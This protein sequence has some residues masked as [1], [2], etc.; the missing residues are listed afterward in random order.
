VGVGIRRA[1]ISIGWCK[2]RG[3]RGE[4][5]FALNPI[6]DSCITHLNTNMGTGRSR[7]GGTPLLQTGSGPR[8]IGARTISGSGY[9]AEIPPQRDRPYGM[10]S[11]TGV[12]PR[13]D[14][15]YKSCYTILM[16]A[17]FFT[18]IFIL[19]SLTVGAVLWWRS[20][21][22]NEG[23]A[24]ETVNVTVPGPTSSI[25]VG[26]WTL[27]GNDVVWGDTSTEIKDVSGYA[28]HGNSSN[29]AAGSATAGRIG[30]GIVFNG[31]SDSVSLG[32][33]YNGVKTVAFW[34]KPNS[35]TQSII[36]LNATATVDIN[37]G[38]V[39]GNNFST[40]TVYVDGA[41]TTTFPDTAWHHIAITTA[42][43]INASAAYLGK[44][45]S[46]Y[47][48]GTLDDIRFYSTEF[49]ATQVADLYKSSGAKQT[50][51]FGM[52][53]T[54][55]D[56]LVG[57]WTMDGDDVKWSDTGTEIKDLSTN[58]NHGDATGTTPVRGKLGQGLQFNG[59]SDYVKLGQSTLAQI[60]V[61]LWFFYNQT[62][63]SGNYALFHRGYAGSCAYSPLISINDLDKLEIAKTDFSCG[64]S[65]AISISK[66]QWN[67]IVMTA[68]NGSQTVYLNGN[69]AANMTDSFSSETYYSTAG[70]AM[71]NDDGNATG[72]YL[73]GKIDD[74][75][76]Y[77]RVLSPM[78]VSNLYNMGK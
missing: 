46:S 7:L 57:H 63:S 11:G 69:L 21:G 29:L 36:D 76:I 48:G 65:A 64:T 75:R 51:S 53:G 35:T 44:I 71:Q 78:E 40:P 49:T 60:S 66:N 3:C 23:K 9:R 67:H 17:R 62:P 26:H 34:V 31:T 13:R 30:Q 59:T 4:I 61:S 24:A 72:D 20:Q 45:A 42:T 43:G 5:S 74:V 56:G 8:C 16:P 37:A 55:T 38:T 6:P 22:K 27:D 77:N 10:H 68:T 25:L 19:L 12:P 18:W 50:V 33:V 73:N 14:R 1:G 41:A 70:A 58:G 32:S 54:M 47:F 39:R 52:E 2:E 15:P 28:K